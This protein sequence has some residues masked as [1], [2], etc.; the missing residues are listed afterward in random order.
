MDAT[1]K[2]Q[3]IPLTDFAKAT[4]DA[5][6][7]TEAKSHIS[8]LQGKVAAHNSIK[9]ID[10]STTFGGANTRIGNLDSAETALE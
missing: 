8:A 1:L 7:T 9:S 5:D 2:S 10:V 4:T 6:F 3:G